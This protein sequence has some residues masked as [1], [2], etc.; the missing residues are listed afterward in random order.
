MSLNA[1]FTQVW[2]GDER[3]FRL[4]IGE[5]LAL[6]EKRD[7][8]CAEILNR[9]G[10]GQW[11]IAD[12]K[13]PIRLGLIGGGVDAR[14]AKDLVEENV[15][16]GRLLEAAVLARNILLAALVA[17]SEEPVGKDDAAAEA[18]GQ[19]ASPPPPSME[20]AQS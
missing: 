3:T 7:L 1:S 12:L 6:E 14:R 15:V 20:Q 16:P 4:G 10:A 9:I 13:E 11:R 2:A 18:P 5:L 8:G 19:N 17:P